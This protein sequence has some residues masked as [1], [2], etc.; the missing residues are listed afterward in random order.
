MVTHCREEMKKGI[1]R[2]HSVVKGEI[3]WQQ[4]GKTLQQKQR[5]QRQV[6]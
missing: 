2:M 1:H 6:L 5:L 4:P 3:T